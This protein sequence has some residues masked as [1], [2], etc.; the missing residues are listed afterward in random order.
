MLV[1][2]STQVGGVV[3]CAKVYNAVAGERGDRYC[4]GMQLDCRKAPSVYHIDFIELS[5][6]LLHATSTCSFQYHHHP[7]L[8]YSGNFSLQAFLHQFHHYSDGLFVF[9]CLPLM[10]KRGPDTTS[11]EHRLNHKQAA[12]CLFSL[13][14]LP[15]LLSSNFAMMYFSKFSKLLDVFLTHFGTIQCTAEQA[16]QAH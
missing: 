15:C 9:F 13:C 7:C 6:V 8:P 12:M 16:S 2:R 1:R 10:Q 3:S 5:A 4:L 14:K 11:G